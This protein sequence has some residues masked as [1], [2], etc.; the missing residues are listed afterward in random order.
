MARTFCTSLFVLLVL[1]LA[2]SP[3]RAVAE[4][5]ASKSNVQVIELRKGWNVVSLNVRPNNLAV[6]VILAPVLK[7]VVMVVDE[8]GQ[9]F[10]PS[11]SITQFT[12]WDLAEAYR[13]FMSAAASVTVSGTAIESDDVEIRLEAGWNLV[14]YYL[15]E[16]QSVSE[17]FASLSDGLVLVKSEDGTLYYPA[18]QIYDLK[19]VEPGS[20][21]AVF[22]TR[23][24]NL[25]LN[26]PGNGNKPSPPDPVD[27]NDGD[28]E[29]N[30]APG[31]TTYTV[32]TIAEALALR[33]LKPGQ[34]VTVRGYHRAGD[35]GEGVFDVMESNC[36]PE[37]GTCFVPEEHQS[38][39][40]EQVMSLSYQKQ[41]LGGKPLVQA[42]VR[43]EVY[44]SD[45]KRALV[46]PGEYLHGHRGSQRFNLRPFLDLTD[47]SF[48]DVRQYVLKYVERDLGGGRYS[49]FYKQAT[50]DIR[51]VRRG[52]TD[53]YNVRWFGAQ[54]ADENPQYDIQPLIATLVNLG[55]AR[56]ISTIYLPDYGVYEYF[57]AIELE[58]GMTLKGAGGTYLATDT[59]DF[60]NT[61]RPVRIRDSHTRLR[62]KDGEALRHLLM[63]LPPGSP[64]YIEPDVK[65]ILQGRRT[66]I[67]SANNVRSMGIENIILD[68]NW[69][70]NRDPFNNR[71]RYGGHSVFEDNLRNSPGYA[72]F[73]STNHGGNVIP[74]GQTITVK[75]VAVLGYAAN[76]VLGNIN[77]WWIGENVLLGNSVWNHVMYYTNGDWTNVTFT[78]FSWTHATP[79]SGIIRNMVFE[80]GAVSPY[81]PATDLMNIRGPDAYDERET[82]SKGSAH[83]MSDGTVAPLG[84]TID[85]FYLDLRSSGIHNPFNGLGSKHQLRNGTIITENSFSGIF[86]EKGNGY[87][88]SVYHS[89]V[90]ANITVIETGSGSSASILNSHNLTDS[91]VS[92]IRILSDSSERGGTRVF[93][94]NAGS[95]D[96]DSHNGRHSIVISN[97]TV[98]APRR[99]VFRSSIAADA[100]GRDIYVRNSSFNNGANGIVV[101]PSQRSSLDGLPGDHSLLRF[102]YDDVELNVGS[103]DQLF[104]ALGYFR[105]VYARNLDRYSED[106]GRISITAAG[107]ERSK[108]IDTRLF[109]APEWYNASGRGAA[110]GIVDHVEVI[111]V[112]ASDKTKPKLRVHF[113]RALESGEKID[114]DW[115]AAVRPFPS[116]FSEAQ[117]E[118]LETLATGQ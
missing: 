81:R 109:W 96:S 29:E 114:L 42:S 105:N 30:D 35:G 37:G 3:L 99:Y 48:H 49:F 100:P 41:Y 98:E 103:N 59:D 93:S 54:T 92:G 115:E 51:L 12:H 6:D 107:G 16:G 101:G 57:G 56:G 4:T 73:V 20:G 71:D 2:G 110:S 72:G 62:V 116:D 27:P 53:T 43:L 5:G 38:E 11:E 46:I 40:I 13:I 18:A 97:V 63:Q 74:V 84:L 67:S 24:A 85:G 34:T 86:L 118:T 111:N 1:S 76:G 113:T 47:A 66:L 45:G 8:G 61:F 21:Y 31:A 82:L 70:G 19:M 117:F 75:N 95:R 7:D 44:G 80:K 14:P 9:I 50:S 112:S 91:A 60:G 69:E 108:D 23:K 68:G 88:R 52:V 78:G 106:K 87:Q 26:N 83:I 22:T 17:A 25:Q 36:V 90:L 33:G 65:Q 10:N 77:N 102:F 32:D 89:N 64:D 104:V 94:M 79:R 28:G 15:Q 55:K 58:D 39:E